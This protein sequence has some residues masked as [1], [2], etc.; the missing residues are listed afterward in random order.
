M[1]KASPKPWEKAC[2]WESRRIDPLL[3]PA[4]GP[5]PLLLN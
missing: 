4:G 3:L 5:E 2:C 1:K